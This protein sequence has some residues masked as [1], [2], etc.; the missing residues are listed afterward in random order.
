V[1]LAGQIPPGW[2][3]IASGA[4]TDTEVTKDNVFP[5][6]NRLAAVPPLSGSVWSL[7]EV[8]TG[9]LKGLGFGAGIFA[10]GRW[11]GDLD[12]S[13]EVP[14]YVRTDATVYYR[15]KD[16]LRAS[17]YVRNLFDVEYIDTTFNQ[18]FIDPGAPLTV[19]G[20]LEVRF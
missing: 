16:Y 9:T 12:N 19:L 8:G 15:I 14:G 13:F 18:V 1:D 11:E 2:Q 17:L 7:C 3:I 10:A 5:V 6:G 4:Y 20:K